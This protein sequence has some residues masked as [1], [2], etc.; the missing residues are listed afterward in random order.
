MIETRGD[1]NLNKGWG[2]LK[3]L[4]IDKSEESQRTRVF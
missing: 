3:E 2:L 1:E 4:V